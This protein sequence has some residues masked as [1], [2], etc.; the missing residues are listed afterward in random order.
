MPNMAIIQ[1]LPD[2]LKHL[3]ISCSISNLLSAL[4]DAPVP[5]YLSTVEPITR[6]HIGAILT[7][8][9]GMNCT[10]YLT[11]REQVKA[12]ALQLLEAEQVETEKRRD[13]WLRTN[14]LEAICAMQRSCRRY[15]IVW[16]RFRRV[17]P[18]AHWTI[19]EVT[20][21]AAGLQSVVREGRILV[22]PVR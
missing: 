3:I 11:W 17:W 16:L 4:F 10:I 1:V 21:Q 8:L 2:E 19:E 22:M 15:R 20:L 12:Y 6:H 18:L 14:T 5:Q 7:A 13:A 9:P